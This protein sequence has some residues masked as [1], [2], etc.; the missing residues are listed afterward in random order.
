MYL[1]IIT[2]SQKRMP[3]H[4][5]SSRPRSSYRNLHSLFHCQRRYRPLFGI[6]AIA[7]RSPARSHCGQGIAVQCSTTLPLPDARSTYQ[8][9]CHCP[10]RCSNQVL[11]R[12]DTPHPI[13]GQRR[14]C[15]LDY[16]VAVIRAPCMLRRGSG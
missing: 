9:R 1:I 15:S 13:G 5:T 16:G 3:R 2:Y 11:S 6:L 12:P 14:D 4:S 10:S 7:T 8:L